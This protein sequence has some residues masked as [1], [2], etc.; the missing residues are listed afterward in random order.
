MTLLVIIGGALGMSLVSFGNVIVHRVPRG[1]SIVWPGSMCSSCAASIAWRDNIPV[2]SF[3]A[4]SGRCRKCRAAIPLSSLFLEIAG[5]IT[6]GA[7]TY[8]LLT[9]F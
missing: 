5:A 6:G 1:Q 3:L 8:A 7:I 2:I 9:M 4:L